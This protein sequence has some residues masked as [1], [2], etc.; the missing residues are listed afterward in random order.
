M[1]TYKS[2]QEGTKH[3]A[4]C[5]SVRIGYIEE[6]GIDRWVWSLNVLNPKG[7]HAT[8]IVVTGEKA[9]AVLEDAWRE[10][11]RAA[12]LKPVEE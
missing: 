5:G 1:I 11:I 6:T 10:W 12:K 7:G 3:A 4:Y 9:R 2:N 8:G